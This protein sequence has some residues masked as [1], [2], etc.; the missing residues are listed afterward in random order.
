MQYWHRRLHR[1][2]TESRRFFSGRWNVSSR[3]TAQLYRRGPASL[4]A[5]PDREVPPKG[6]D[7][8]GR[9]PGL[10][11]VLRDQQDRVPSE[12][13]PVTLR[14]G[15]CSQVTDDRSQVPPLLQGQGRQRDR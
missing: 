6:A 9:A 12:G 14:R 13:G 8:F 1:S 5:G 15:P 10:F 7:G 3:G 2:V 11:E 4:A